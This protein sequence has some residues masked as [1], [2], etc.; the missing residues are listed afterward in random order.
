MV[1]QEVIDHYNLQNKVTDDKWIYCELLKALYE[2]KELEKLADIKLQSFLATEGYKP[3]CFTHGSYKHEH[4][5]HFLI[6]P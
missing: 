3:Y 4:K 5:Y 2:L 1:P 6:G